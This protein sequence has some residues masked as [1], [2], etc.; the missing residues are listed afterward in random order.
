[1]DC[2]DIHFLHIFHV[3]PPL[4]S[5]RV[6]WDWI[7]RRHEAISSDSLVFH[8]RPHYVPMTF[9]C[10]M[11]WWLSVLCGMDSAIRKWVSVQAPKSYELSRLWLFVC[12]VKRGVNR[13]WIQLCSFH[14]Q[15]SSVHIFFMFIIIVLF[16]LTEVSLIS[17]QNVSCTA[18]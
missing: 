6:S 10:S 9:L 16:F 5:C 8:L 15:Y 17:Y 7:V 3:P 12:L 13:S 11:Y 4:L 14:F 18:C 2:V 1:M